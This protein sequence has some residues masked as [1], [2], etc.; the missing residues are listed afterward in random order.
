VRQHGLSWGLIKFRLLSRIFWDHFSPVEKHLRAV[1]DVLGLVVGPHRSPNDTR[2]AVQ[3]CSYLGVHFNSVVK[4]ARHEVMVVDGEQFDRR[5][6]VDTVAVEIRILH[7]R[8]EH[9]TLLRV[10]RPID[11]VLNDVRGQGLLVNW[12]LVMVIRRTIRNVEVG[13]FEQ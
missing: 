13:H 10:Y 4:A 2:L 3:V 9:W 6:R 5:F 7:L 11:L 1:V 8:R 12:E